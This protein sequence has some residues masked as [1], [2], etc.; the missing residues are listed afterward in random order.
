MSRNGVLQCQSMLITYCRSGGSSSGAREFINTRLSQFAADHPHISISVVKRSNRHPNISA[1]YLNNST[2]QI[3]LANLPS[4]R[5]AQVIQSLNDHINVKSPNKWH[6][7]RSR[8]KSITGL[9]DPTFNF[10]SIA[11]Q[12]KTRI[13]QNSSIIGVA[14]TEILSGESASELQWKSST[15]STPATATATESESSSAESTTDKNSKSQSQ[16]Q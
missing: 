1:T 14:S 2:A 7:V 13:N 4:N 8:N 3:T 10:I 16:S 11:D 12:I 5:C 9:W 15:A 6:S